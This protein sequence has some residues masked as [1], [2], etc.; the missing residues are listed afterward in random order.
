MTVCQQIHT[1]CTDLLHRSWQNAG[2]PN[3]M[4]CWELSIRTVCAMSV[5]YA[6]ATDNT[7]SPYTMWETY[8][9]HYTKSVVKLSFFMIWRHMVEWRTTSI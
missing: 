5:Y 7:F 4:S 2:P 3:W 6:A 1:A 9:H 8:N